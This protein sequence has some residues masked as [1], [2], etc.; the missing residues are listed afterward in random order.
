M[1]FAVLY[2]FHIAS[3]IFLR[4]ARPETI[5]TRSSLTPKYTASF[6]NS[7]LFALLRSGC[8]LIDMAIS[9]PL[10][11]SPSELIL[12]ET[13]YRTCSGWKRVFENLLLAGSNYDNNWQV[14]VLN[15]E[16]S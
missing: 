5:L 1:A 3:T 4:E 10:T 14:F 16:E 13:K 12:T 2:V 9:S 8:D 6:F 11:L 15:A 7:S